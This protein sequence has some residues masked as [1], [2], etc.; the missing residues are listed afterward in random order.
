MARW[1]EFSKQRPPILDNGR[2]VKLYQKV[3]VTNNID[4]RDAFGNPSHVWLGQPHKDKKT[5]WSLYDGG[6]Y[7]T[8]W[9]DPFTV[10]MPKNHM[11]N[12]HKGGTE[13]Y[14]ATEHFNEGWNSCL[15]EMAKLHEVTK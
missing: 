9:M 8:H 3:L 15:N 2:G 7:L 4:A 11:R 1:I 5:G 12:P 14:L 10:E 13:A 6:M